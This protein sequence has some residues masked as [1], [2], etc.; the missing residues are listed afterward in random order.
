MPGY[1]GP[2]GRSIEGGH[3][4]AQCTGGSHRYIDLKVFGHQ[5]IYDEPTC[6]AAYQCH[7]PYDP[8]GLVGSFNAVLLT[9]MGIMAGRVL[10][11]HKGAIARVKR[12]GMMGAVA[13]LVAALLCNFSKEGG[14]IPVNKNLW[15]TSFVLVTAGFGYWV[16]ALLYVVVDELQWWDGAPFRYTGM[17]SIVVYVGSE[18]L[19]GYFPFYFSYSHYSH[20]AHLAANAMGAGMWNAVATYLYHKGVF[21]KV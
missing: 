6:V 18:V 21:I 4:Y 8:E 11:Y 10:I 2:G 5:H 20:W 19:E 17:N 12:L 13:T 7:T 14:A 15:S 1:L 3:G 9:Y 16:L